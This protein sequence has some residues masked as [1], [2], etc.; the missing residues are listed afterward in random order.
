MNPYR[1][2]EPDLWQQG[3]ED[4]AQP[5][6]LGPGSSRYCLGSP[7]VCYDF[8]NTC[9]IK[10]DCTLGI[11]G[12]NAPENLK[13]IIYRISRE[14]LNNAAKHSGAG[15]VSV[16]LIRKHGKIL[17]MIGPGHKYSS[18]PLFRCSLRI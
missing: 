7:F 4:S 5:A 14:A 18:F 6:A 2:G 11:D 3:N 17:L 16:S 1:V 10:T 15:H 8:E 13:I 9:S 12:V